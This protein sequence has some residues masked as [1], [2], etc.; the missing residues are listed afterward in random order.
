MQQAA[1]KEA[2]VSLLNHLPGAS[3]RL[4]NLAELIFGVDGSGF[5]LMG[6]LADGR[7]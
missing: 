1:R 5:V 3:T 7:V 6:D 2:G 4:G